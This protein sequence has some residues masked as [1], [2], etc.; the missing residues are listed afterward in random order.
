MNLWSRDENPDGTGNAVALM[1]GYVEVLRPFNVGGRTIVPLARYN[2]SGSDD[3]QALAESLRA[4]TLH[5]GYYPYGNVR[6]FA[7]YTAEQSGQSNNNDNR[8]TMQFDVTF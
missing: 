7:E 4:Y 5:V 2:W 1:A 3:D 6:A 8:L